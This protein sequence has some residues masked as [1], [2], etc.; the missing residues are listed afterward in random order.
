M[1]AARPDL[2]IDPAY[3]YV[4]AIGEGLSGHMTNNKGFTGYQLQTNTVSGFGA[5]GTDTFGSAAARL[6]RRGFIP[7]DFSEG[8]D[9]F[10]SYQTNEKGESVKSADFPDLTRGLTALAGMLA[11]SRSQFLR[12]AD[13]YLGKDWKDGL[14]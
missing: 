3:L 10:V 14:S 6:Q 1:A 13:R 12:D 7:K 9:Y 4:M 8:E 11:E 2:G 5:L